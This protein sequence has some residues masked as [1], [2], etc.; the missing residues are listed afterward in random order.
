MG[1]GPL[2]ALG[3]LERSHDLRAATYLT[4]AELT[5]RGLLGLRDGLQLITGY[6]EKY[7]DT[8]FPRLDEDDDNDPTSRINAL[9]ALN[10]PGGVLRR[11]RVSP[12]Y[13]LA[14]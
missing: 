6:L 4:E 11:L 8:V 12:S 9:A 13:V 10:N 14:A 2:T 1:Y 3:I 5:A 7:W